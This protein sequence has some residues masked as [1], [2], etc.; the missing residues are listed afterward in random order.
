MSEPRVAVVTG[1]SSGIGR[2]VAIALGTLGWR[3]ALGARGVDK[4]DETA[5]LVIEAGG[6]AYPRTL[7]V[8]DAAS[9]DG[10]VALVE[11][12]MGPID[13]LVNNA[14]IAVP[15]AFWELAPDQLDHEIRTNL[16]GPLLCTRRVLPSMIRRG[17]GDVV[18]VSSDTAR[19]PRPRMLGYSA[20][21]AGIEVA[22]RSL[23]MELEGTGVRSTTVR[24]GPTLTDFASG[25][26][27]QQVTDLMDYWPRFGIQR[28]LNTL[29]PDDIARA[30]VYAVT[31]PPGV[32]VDVVEVQPEA[33]MER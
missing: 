27:Q 10:F 31:S 20:S 13:V 30:V 4:L 3:V 14:G 9:V 5:G 11:D 1:S 24:V 22:A 16:L 32:H 18:F 7:D 26:T 19:A 15:G 25:W 8:T 17:R 29:H 33:P 28:H 21:K 12:V 6:E 2:A 23:A